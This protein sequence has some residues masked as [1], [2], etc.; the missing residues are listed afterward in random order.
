[1]SLEFIQCVARR[2][3]RFMMMIPFSRFKIELDM[4]ARQGGRHVAGWNGLGTHMASQ[5]GTIG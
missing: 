5:I 3:G 2:C 1:M 4:M